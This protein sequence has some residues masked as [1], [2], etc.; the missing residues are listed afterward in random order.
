MPISDEDAKMTPASTIPRHDIDWVYEYHEISRYV[1]CERR[2]TQQ[3][4]CPLWGERSNKQLL[5]NG[6]TFVQT[7]TNEKLMRITKRCD[8]QV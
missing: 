5:Q 6:K 3:N 2:Q 4:I 8:Q 7:P 1:D